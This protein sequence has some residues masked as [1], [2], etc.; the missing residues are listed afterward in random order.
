M[1][2]LATVRTISDIKPIPEADLI[3]LA[4]VD[5][6]QCVIKKGT[7]SV[8]ER[9]IYCEVDSV[10]PVHPEY[11]YLR[12]SCYVQKDWL[13]GGEGFRLRTIKL[14]KQISQ[15]LLLPIAGAKSL[16]TWLGDIYGEDVSDALGIVKWEPPVPAN[17]SGLVKGNFPPYI[18]K[19]DQERV[20]NLTQKVFHGNPDTLW[21]VTLKLDGSSCTFY[22]KDGEVGVCSRNMDLK[23]EQTGNAFVDMFHRL[24]LAEKL[25]GCGNIAVQGELMGPKI[26]G[27]RE[28]LTDYAFYAYNIWDIDK[29]QYLGSN[30]RNA[31]LDRLGL[32][33]VPTLALNT[34]LASIGCTSIRDMLEYVKRPSINHKVAEGVVFKN[35]HGSDH[36]GLYS[37]KC[38]SNTYLLGGK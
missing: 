7:F 16:G 33:L 18:P 21:E 22:H 19:T 20:Q 9:V 11:E 8:G 15:G 32:C 28:G 37:F 34:T 30:L 14:R 12:K 17:L 1:R 38:I 29:Q 23:L 26:Q 3:E 10:L 25:Q 36:S 13:P 2:K 5:G 27:N 31:I 24:G 6:W 35:V 4:I